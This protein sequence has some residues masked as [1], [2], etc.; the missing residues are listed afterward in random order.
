MDPFAARIPEDRLD[1]V[2]VTLLDMDDTFA[3]R[4]KGKHE[5]FRIAYAGGVIIGYT[6][7]S[8]VA[9]TVGAIELLRKVL[10]EMDFADEG[11]TVIGSDEAGKGEWLGPLVVC[12]V[13]LSPEQSKELRALGVQDSK[14]LT[15]RQI[16]NRAY[17]I[18]R[19]SLAI[20]SV[21]IPPDT[22][23]KRLKEMRAEGKNLN[24][25]LAWAHAKAI[26]QAYRKLEARR[27]DSEI[28][29]VIDEF[30]QAKARL[31]LEREIDL[32]SIELIQK[33]AAEDVIAV[34][35]ASIMA[36]D[37]RDTWIDQTSQ[38][39]GFELVGM[40]VQEAKKRKNLA[41]FAKISYMNDA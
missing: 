7:G 30:A 38:E 36:R 16:G 15:P 11:K 32:N 29:V 17:D 1:E 9:N 24:D 39:L 40:T 3:R 31:R 20:E 23:E 35:A 18:E 41:R 34:A 21:L 4:P 28:K 6:T 5:V 22:F 14:E 37:I 10:R 25:L 26:S 27:E 13:A 12:A 19:N 2:R 8:V 33:P